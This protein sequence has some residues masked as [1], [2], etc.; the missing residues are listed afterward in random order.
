MTLLLVMM[1][2]FVFGTILFGVYLEF[3]PFEN[4]RQVPD[5][6]RGSIVANI[7]LFVLAEIG[8]LIFG[9]Q[10]VMAQPEVAQAKEVTLGMGLALLGIGLPTAMATIGAGIAV[11]PVASAAL[12]VIAEKPEIFG[13]SLVFLGLAEGIAIYGLVI[14]IILLGRI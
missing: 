5:W 10:D 3:R 4:T 7:A 9:V 13:R 6:L 1:T 2:L 11:G 8:L 12:A 14:S